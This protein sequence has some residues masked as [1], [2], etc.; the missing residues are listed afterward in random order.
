MN[1]PVA[2]DLS[3]FLKEIAE[4]MQDPDSDERRWALFDLE[5]QHGE[6]V[7]KLLVSGIQDPHRAVREAAAEVLESQRP[8]DCGPH[9]IPLL[10]HETIEVR[11]AAAAVLVNF[12]EESVVD[13]IPALKDGNE[14]VRK[15]SADILGLAGSPEAV[16]HLCEAARSD[17]VDNVVVSAIE[18]LGKIGSADAVPVL[19]EILSRGE[20]MEA[21]TIEAL[22]LIGDTAA[23]DPLMAM[24]SNED[25]I[26]A[27]AA[28]DALG[29][30]GDLQ[31]LPRLIDYLDEAAEFMIEPLVMAIMGI[32]H[33]NGRNV[34]EAANENVIKAAVLLLA[35]GH[36]DA[37]K[38]FVELTQQGMS[39]SL[40]R[41]FFNHI[42]RLPP[43]VVVPL[44]K[45]IPADGD[46]SA[47]LASMTRHEDEWVAY[48]AMETLTRH[49]P[50]SARSLT[51]EMLRNMDGL[52]LMAAIRSAGELQLVEALPVLETLQ[53]S[54]N[55]DIQLESERAIAVLKD[56]S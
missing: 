24:L 32:G 38:R 15:F 10:G 55:E 54:E 2:Q 16:P 13:L 21:E 36:Q 7:V 9:L 45:S 49:D 33:K 12:G 43:N 48:T 50:D 31:V 46:F 19:N 37:T 29:N 11:N 53:T 8:S 3:P 5:G 30:L 6:S 18:A 41:Q 51:L 28:V 14:D 1:N 52:R 44:V 17:A 42:K 26:I 39:E 47:E 40:L 27:Y 25:P 20:G 56:L 34:F 35:E 22:G 4:R 23:I